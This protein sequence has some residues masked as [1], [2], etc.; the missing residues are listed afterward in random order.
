MARALLPGRRPANLAGAA[1]CAAMMGFALYAQY[2]LHLTPCNLCILQRVCVVALGAVF[3]V[4]ALHDP[5]RTGAR[6]YG[7]AIGLVALAGVGVSGRHVWVQMQPPGSLPSCGADIAT[8]LDMMPAWEVVARI[9]RGGGECQTILWSLLGISMPA[10]VLIAV[11]IVG[12]AGVVA[13]L[14]PGPVPGRPG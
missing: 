3:L 9:L 5:G 6:L 14:A 13:N 7:A 1:A 10:W 8:M 4:A 2:G 11:A 12:S